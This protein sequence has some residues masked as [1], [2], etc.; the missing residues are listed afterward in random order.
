M[1]KKNTLI[2]QADDK[3]IATWKNENKNGIYAVPVP[4]GGHIAYF[5]N[6][7]RHDVNK[8]FEVAQEEDS[9]YL[10]ATE[11]FARLCY[12]GG[13]DEVLKNDMMFLSAAPYLRAKMNPMEAML[14]NL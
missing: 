5:R 2:G 11:E 3:Q 10:T 9:K 14:V 1:S 4:E 7:T 6:P 8:A 13:S 12:I